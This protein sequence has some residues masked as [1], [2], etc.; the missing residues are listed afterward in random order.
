MWLHRALL[1]APFFSHSS[2]A[3]LS[4]RIVNDETHVKKKTRDSARAAKKGRQHASSFFMHA[5]TQYPGG[6][7][8]QSGSGAGMTA[9]ES[10]PTTS[11][12]S[13]S[14]ERPRTM[15]AAAAPPTTAAAAGRPSRGGRSSHRSTQS[16]GSLPR[17][18]SPSRVCRCASSGPAATPASTPAPSPPFFPPLRYGQRRSGRRKGTACHA[19]SGDTA[20]SCTWSSQYGSFVGVAVA[21]V[22]LWT[23]LCRQSWGGS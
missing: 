5:R 10:S 1:S 2:S 7:K 13:L 15:A 18:D 20:S 22:P 8:D 11:H 14:R 4:H 16:C 9:A 19:Q 21:F 3:T 17:A 12:L 6:Y 23:R